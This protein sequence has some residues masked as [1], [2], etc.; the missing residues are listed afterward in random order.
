MVNKILN[1]WKIQ[2][3]NK[4]EVFALIIG[5]NYRC[6]LVLLK[7]ELPLMILPFDNYINKLV[8]LLSGPNMLVFQVFQTQLS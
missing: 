4:N 3:Q 8:S 6:Y 1:A 2:E 7:N 5:V